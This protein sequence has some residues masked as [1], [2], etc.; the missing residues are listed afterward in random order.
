[1]GRA[2]TA[3]RLF[4]GLFLIANGL[5]FWFHF[6]PLNRP[7]SDL[8][9]QLMDAL[10]ATRLIEM[11]KFVEMGAGL[12]L[13]ANRYV[14]LAMLVMTPLSVIIFWLDFVLIGTPQTIIYG[15][16]LLIPQAWLMASLA[17]SYAPIL[18]PRHDYAAP[19]PGNVVAA[20]KEIGG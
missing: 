19:T 8:A 6:L 7:P 9:N 15:V 16:L 17:R 2:T 10:I 11:V 20:L 18:R 3:M 1:M 14:P 4:L 12:A 5:N 13:L